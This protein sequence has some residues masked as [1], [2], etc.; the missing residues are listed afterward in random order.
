MPYPTSP[1]QRVVL[2]MLVYVVAAIACVALIGWI[3]GIPVLT[4]IVPG[5]VSMKFNTALGFL[6][7]AG[8]LYAALEYRPAWQLWLALPAAVLGL[9]TLF[10]Y[11]SG[12]NLG[13]DQALFQDNSRSIYPGRMTPL[14][15]VNFLLLSG[16]LLTP[17]FKRCNYIKEALA[18]LLALSSTFA[19]VGYIYGVPALYSALSD[20]PTAMAMHTGA[21]FLLLAI[22]FLLVP[23]DEGFVR[24]LRGPS[25]ASMAARYMLFPAILV[26]VVLGG[27]FIRSRW[28][29]GHPNLVMALSVV[30]DIVLLVA[31]IWLFAVMIQRVESER[32]LIQRQAETDRLT[33]IYNR[34]HFETSLEHEI[35]RARRY[36]SPLSLLMI[37]VD[38]FKM[39][40]DRHGHLAGDRLLYQLTRECE[41]C[42][43]ASDVFCRFGGDEF[44]IIAPVTP[45]PA[46]L[47]LA[48]RI[49][50]NVEDMATD[51]SLGALAVSIGIAVWEENF[52]TNDDFIAAADN[53]LYQAK[54]AGRNRECLYSPKSLS[55]D[56]NG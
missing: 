50:K 23:R 36:G 52:K 56:I 5:L 4:S 32:E 39:L 27:L 34:R 44:V 7:L 33:G 10:E 35:Q 41:S 18:L 22:V 12:I 37:D 13:I 53:A 42:L 38:H 47:A 19:I 54:T 9:M 15:A 46:A 51:R 31:L 21:C 55:T 20:S 16:A 24:I 45:G 26:P 14:S 43:R 8:S 28:N 6:L 29:L 11:V 3:F 48:R 17:S 30:S 2:H 40:N 25:I 1:P 49:R